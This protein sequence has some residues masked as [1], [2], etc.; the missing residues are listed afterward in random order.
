[1]IKVKQITTDCQFADQSLVR[2]KWLLY[3]VCTASY[4]HCRY[5]MNTLEIQSWP[6]RLFRFIPLPSWLAILLLWQGVFLIDYLL[7]MDSPV[8]QEHTLEYGFLVL[9]FALVCISIIYCSRVLKGLFPDVL[10][11]IES[12]ERPLKDWY[13]KKLAL[14]GLQGGTCHGGEHAIGNED[15]RLA[16][17]EDVRDGVGVQ[18][19][20]DGVQDRTEHL[21]A[22]VRLQHC[23][24]VRQHGGYDITVLH[25]GFL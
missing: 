11:F 9:F 25:P 13:D 20:V 3:L 2:T 6:E 22:V 14:K 4:L 17:F 1:M 19:C 8:F 16:V 5:N 15:L 23:R 18:A 21:H 12:P 7:T 24:D 10:L